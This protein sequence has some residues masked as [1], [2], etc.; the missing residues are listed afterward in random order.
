MPSKWTHHLDFQGISQHK[1][2]SIICFLDL[3]DE[4][5]KTTG[6]FSAKPSL[7]EFGLFGKAFNFAFPVFGT[8]ISRI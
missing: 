1:L 3:K 4:E 5:I 6:S 2:D 7:E 8:M